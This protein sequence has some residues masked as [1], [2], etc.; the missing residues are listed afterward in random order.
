MVSLLLVVVGI[1]DPTLLMPQP[2]VMPSSTVQASTARGSSAW[3]SRSSAASPCSAGQ[4]VI[5]VRV[6]ASQVVSAPYRHVGHALI[7]ERDSRSV[8]RARLRPRAREGA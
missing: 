5:D 6:D 8:A 4:L 1:A 2:Q 7:N 3:S